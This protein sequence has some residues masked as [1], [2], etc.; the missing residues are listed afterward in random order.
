MWRHGE[1]LALLPAIAMLT[2][3]D[4]EEHPPEALNHPGG[5]RCYY[6]ALADGCPS[7][8]S[9]DGLKFLC[10]CDYTDNKWFYVLGHYL[11]IFRSG[12][13]ERNVMAQTLKARPE[14]GGVSL[15]LGL[16]ERVQC[17]TEHAKLWPGT[18]NLFDTNELY[19][20][21]GS[22][23]YPQVRHKLMQVCVPGSMALQLICQHALLHGLKDFEA[24]KAYAL[25]AH[26]LWQMVN[27]C[28][29]R[30][31]PFPFP[32]LGE[33]LTSWTSE[34]LPESSAIAWYPDPNLMR[35]KRPEESEQHYWPCAPLK[36]PQCFPSGADN[37]FTS[38]SECCDPG[39]G[40]LGDANCWVGEWTF[41][42][43]CR[44]PN[45]GGRF[46]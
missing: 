22:I 31:T 8:I 17:S 19:T 39:K 10:T 2:L 4:A 14:A 5:P 3:S 38:C 26:Q 12:E 41:A 13:M 16:R 32:G 36:D 42:R 45:D 37:L 40:P 18:N 15:D 28:V 7:S 30:Q 21:L 43:C 27:K 9:A 23:I 29:E 24:A 46:Y 25:Q 6:D 1:L 20:F 34:G 11:N 33:F 44:T 35:G